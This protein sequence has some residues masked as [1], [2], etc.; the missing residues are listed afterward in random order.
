[1]REVAGLHRTGAALAEG[2]WPVPHGAALAGGG[3][4]GAARGLPSRDGVGLCRM[5]AALV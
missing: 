4:A 1:L 2:D 3:R 5:G